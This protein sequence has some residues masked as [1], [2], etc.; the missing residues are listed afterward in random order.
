MTRARRE[1]G[2]QRTDAL[3]DRRRRPNLFHPQLEQRSCRSAPT[4]ARCSPASKLTAY[5]NEDVP[6]LYRYDSDADR[7]VCVSC[8]PS[9]A[10]PSERPTLGTTIH[11]SGLSPRIKALSTAPTRFLS[12]SGD[13][14]FFETVEALVGADRNGAQD[15]YE[16]EAPGSGSCEEDASAFSR[17]DEGC[18]T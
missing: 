3:S 8:N 4:G 14:V 13:R 7:I 2:E 12:A 18:P 10:V 11:F 9:G 1:G 15:V 17:Q 5:D 6:E 16:W